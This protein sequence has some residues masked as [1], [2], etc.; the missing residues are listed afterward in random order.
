[1][2]T[3]TTAGLTMPSPSPWLKLLAWAALAVPVLPLHA[4]TEWDLGRQIFLE[5]ARPACAL[6]HTLAEAGATGGIGPVLDE[7]KPERERV[8]R[9]V[10]A[11][12]GVM[13]AFQGQLSESEIQAVARYVSVASGAAAP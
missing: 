3:A 9:A 12:I 2:A 13:P 11:G 6:C 5:R 8:A 1:V 7:L 10:S 4:D